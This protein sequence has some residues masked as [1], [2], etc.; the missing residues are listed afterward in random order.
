MRIP[1]VILGITKTPHVFVL[2]KEGEENI[3]KYIGAID[4]NYENAAEATEHFVK[5]AVNS[6]VKGESVKTTKTVAIGCSIK[7]RK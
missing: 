4:N 7:V 6:H 3:V 2:L 5:D 1:L